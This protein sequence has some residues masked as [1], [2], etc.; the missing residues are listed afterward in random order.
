MVTVLLVVLALVVGYLVADLMLSAVWFLIR[1]ALGLVL[2]AVLFV[3]MSRWLRS[4]S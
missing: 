3:L 1:L 2:A 4:R